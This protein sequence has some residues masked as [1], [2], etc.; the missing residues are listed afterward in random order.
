MRPNAHDRVARLAEE[1]GAM[2]VRRRRLIDQAALLLREAESR[3]RPP[4]TGTEDAEAPRR[5]R[6]R[7]AR[8]PA[9]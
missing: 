5:V 3:I 1:I 6:R 4:G 9:R 8:D 7:G 2:L